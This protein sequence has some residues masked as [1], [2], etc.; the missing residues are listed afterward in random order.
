MKHK[1]NRIPIGGND[2]FGSTWNQT[3]RSIATT[4][5]TDK[6]IYRPHPLHLGLITFKPSGKLD[7][8]TRKCREENKGV[9]GSLWNKGEKTLANSSISLS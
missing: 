7:P 5:S 1:V 2:L 4:H 3:R 6:G 9:E 8:N